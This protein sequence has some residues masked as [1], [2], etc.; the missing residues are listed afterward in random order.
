M[1]PHAPGPVAH[2]TVSAVGRPTC[3]RS[4]S[5]LPGV[6]TRKLSQSNGSV[7]LRID[8]ALRVFVVQP[9]K[10]LLA[11]FRNDEA[12]ALSGRAHNLMRGQLRPSPNNRRTGPPR[13]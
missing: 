4:A 2:R 12:H 5:S 1:L 13:R 11:E 8:S 10:R 6:G 3:S 7:A 9:L